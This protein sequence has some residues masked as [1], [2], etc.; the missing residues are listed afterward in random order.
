MVRR[1]RLTLKG[2]RDAETLYAI[3]DRYHEF[4]R[5]D[6]IPL[7]GEHK[8]E[9]HYFRITHIQRTTLNEYFRHHARAWEASRFA[10]RQIGRPVEVDEI[11]SIVEVDRAY[12]Y[13]WE[14]RPQPGQQRF[15]VIDD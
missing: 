14:E 7:R 5:G 1:L 3:D 12:P 15:R 11:L 2:E 6:I 9:T 4:H 8:G 10:A 13:Q